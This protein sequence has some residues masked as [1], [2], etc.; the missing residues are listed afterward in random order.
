MII[1]AS[2]NR[3]FWIMMNIFFFFWGGWGGG[4]QVLFAS[5][6]APRLHAMLAQPRSHFYGTHSTE[7]VQRRFCR[8]QVDLGPKSLQHSKEMCYAVWRP[9]AKHCCDGVRRDLK[10]EKNWNG[11]FPAATAVFKITMNNRNGGTIRAFPTAS[12]TGPW[13]AENSSFSFPNHTL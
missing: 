7:P 3:C 2:P 8:I 9:F 1:G 4:V 13:F 10:R 6:M 5:F 11:F 12:S